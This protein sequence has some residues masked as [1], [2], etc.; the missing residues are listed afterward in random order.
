MRRDPVTG[1]VMTHKALNTLLQAAGSIVMKLGMCYLDAWIKKR[2]MKAHQV[3]MIHDECQFSCPWS[4]VEVLRSLIDRFV[5]TAGKQLN[6]EIELASDN[7]FGTNWLET[8]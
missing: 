7:M 5:S 2:N 6:M 1:E 4:E 3:L 8:H